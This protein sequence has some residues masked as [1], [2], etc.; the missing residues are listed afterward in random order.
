MM[1]RFYFVLGLMLFAAGVMAQRLTPTDYIA[2]YKDIAIS[3]MKRSGV[4]AAITLAQGILESESGNSDLV[5][6]SNNHFGIK[7]KSNWT[8]DSVS[9]DDD[10]LGECFRAYKSSEES[11]IDHSDFL[12]NSPRYASLF[13]LSPTDYKSWARGLKKAGYATNPRYADILIRNIEMYNLNQYDEEL[14]E[15]T[16][17]VS[18][19]IEPTPKPVTPAEII[20]EMA[21]PEVATK[22]QE[23][24]TT[25]NGS[26]ALFVDKG[27]SLLAIATQNNIKLSRLLEYNELKK[28]G[29]LE[30]DA[31]I[32]LEKKQKEG[33]KEETFSEAGETLYDV[34]QKNGILLTSLCEY[35][36]LTPTSVLKPGTRLF[37]K[38]QATAA[39]NIHAASYASYTNSA[40][41]KSLNEK[42]KTHEVLPKEGLYSIAK[43]YGVSISEIKEWNNLRSDNLQ[44]GQIL[45][46]SK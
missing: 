13:N 3:E 46:I 24:R 12:K 44:T 4:P 6:R 31:I 11:F 19:P 36:A 27:T 16:I 22:P 45:I 26:R 8:G 32:F 41:S 9:H 15:E 5:R 7:C 18:A 39:A 14:K 42:V 17:I 38:P 28:D 2:K 33:N 1:K 20:K 37:L 43:K 30:K 21:K 34:A 10:E 25:I 35:N 29:L 40:P 23:A